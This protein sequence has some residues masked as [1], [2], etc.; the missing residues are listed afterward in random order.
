MG[1]GDTVTDKVEELPPPAFWQAARV[2]FG[3]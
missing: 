1:F 3:W 2:L